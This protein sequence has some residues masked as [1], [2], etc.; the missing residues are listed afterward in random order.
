MFSILCNLAQTKKGY[1]LQK[2]D[3][4]IAVKSTLKVIY[5][6]YNIQKINSTDEKL[7][8][9]KQQQ[10]VCSYKADVRTVDN[11]KSVFNSSTCYLKCQ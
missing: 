2:D 3:E 7:P 9:K 11:F 6:S 8:V 10:N 1:I 5:F 4:K